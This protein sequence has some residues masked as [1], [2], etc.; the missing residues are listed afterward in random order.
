MDDVRKA[1]ENQGMLTKDDILLQNNKV[2]FIYPS[3]SSSS[4]NSSFGS[5]VSSIVPHDNEF[6]NLLTTQRQVSLQAGSISKSDCEL[7]REKKVY[8]DVDSQRDE[9]PQ[10]LT[11]TFGDFLQKSSFKIFLVS[12]L[13]KSQDEKHIQ[14][15]I[16]V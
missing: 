10:K 6:N 2:N 12:D 7:L 15:A 4:L 1:L 14:E 11:S 16:N 5:P 13:S 3:S 8:D 9:R